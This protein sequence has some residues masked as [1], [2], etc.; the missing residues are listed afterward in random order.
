MFNP[1][2]PGRRYEA[3]KRHQTA[4]FP[5]GLADAAADLAAWNLRH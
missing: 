3:S 4:A 5:A 2:T 1:L